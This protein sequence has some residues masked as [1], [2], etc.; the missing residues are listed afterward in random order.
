MFKS[1]IKNN[2]NNI[3][4]NFAYWYSFFMHRKN[5]PTVA[6]C[7]IAVAM[8]VRRLLKEH[9]IQAIHMVLY[10]WVTMLYYNSVEF[11]V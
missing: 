3:I 7:Y 10:V 4:R 9:P 6:L 8:L 2:N 5:Q 1:G 11:C